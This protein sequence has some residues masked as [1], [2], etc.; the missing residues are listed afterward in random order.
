MMF[1]I[2]ESRI[3]RFFCMQITAERARELFDYDPSE[4]VLRWKKNQKGPRAHT[5]GKPAGNRHG[6]CFVV[7][8]DGK[9]HRAHNIAWLVVHG[10][11]P[12]GTITHIDADR[13]NN[14]LANLRDDPKSLTSHEDGELTAERLRSLMDYAPDSGLFTWR[15]YRGGSRKH[16]A[17]C[18]Q[19]RWGYIV[20]RVDGRLY[21][22]HR[23]AWLYVHGRWPTKDI[24][25]VN[26]IKQDNRINNLREADRYQNCGNLKRLLKNNTSGHRGVVRVR[27][28]DKWIAQ[29]VRH[30][31]PTHLGR[32]DSKEAAIHAYNEAAMAHFGEFY[33][34]PSEAAA[35]PE[36]S[37][38]D[39]YER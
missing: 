17:T 30:G 34:N 22:A 27:N 10:A 39:P 19:R 2:W 4:G 29:I 25:H 16:P 31:V 37:Q 28:S 5:S 33:A 26:G 8:I 15:I 14:R 3:P 24:D 32:F 21:N 38:R 35:G 20:I 9:Q 11:W 13:T 12:T 1:L 18:L 7:E 6:G 23:L 36:A